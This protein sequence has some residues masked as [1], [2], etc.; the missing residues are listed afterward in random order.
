MTEF[1]R[2]SNENRKTNPTDCAKLESPLAKSGDSMRKIKLATGVSFSRREFQNRE[3][4]AIELG[5]ENLS[6]VSVG[7]N[8]RIVRRQKERQNLSNG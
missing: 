5:E 2:L 4:V 8:F 7:A 1:K 3:A 6:I